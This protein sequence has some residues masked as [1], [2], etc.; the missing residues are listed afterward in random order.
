MLLSYPCQRPAAVFLLD[1]GKYFFKK[2]LDIGMAIFDIRD[3]PYVCWRV[4]FPRECV[5]FTGTS[6]KEIS[7]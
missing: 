7:P 1:I 5:P 2:Y 6:K 3:Y 4:L